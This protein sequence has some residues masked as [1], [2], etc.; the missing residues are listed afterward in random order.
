M[1]VPAIETVARV[2]DGRHSAAPRQSQWGT[3]IRRLLLMLALLLA[4]TFA[5]GPSIAVSYD[6]FGHHIWTPVRVI[7]PFDQSSRIDS[8]VVTAGFGYQAAG[9][10]MIMVRTYDASTGVVLSDD[11]FDL[12]VTGEGLAEADDG[13][14]GRI[15]AGGIGLD[16]HGKSTFMLSVY[17]AETG[18]FLWEGQLNLLKVDDEGVSK[19]MA[20][21]SPNR[22]A[23]PLAAGGGPTTFDTLFSVRAVN[24]MTGGLVWQDQFTPGS[25]RRAQAKVISIGASMPM[26]AGIP[27]AHIFDLI[28]RT[29]DHTS[30]RLL[31]QDSFEPLDHV[32]NVPETYEYPQATPF[33]PVLGSSAATVLN[34][35]LP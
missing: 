28:V 26:T 24:P 22:P 15:F 34:A 4:D 32:E 19:V 31:W 2:T 8:E 29:Y 5:V 16:Q 30:G 20:R 3:S 7:G 11:S 14:Q 35:A 18:K 25:R 23:V 21:I 27:I 1:Q 6:I 17:D 33:E 13:Q 12:S 10:S 9:S